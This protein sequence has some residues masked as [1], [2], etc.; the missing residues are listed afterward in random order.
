M[1]TIIAAAAMSVLG[2]AQVSAESIEIRR[3]GQT[4]SVIGK[5]D[6][7]S[8]HAVVNP[9]LP[10]NE[11]TRANLGRVDFA[12]GARTA[13]HTH[14]AGQLLIVTAGKGWVQEEGK[15]RQDITSGDVVWIPATVRHWHG[16]TTTSPMSHLAMTYMV[17]G[18]NVD[19]QEPVS[20][21]Q[22]Q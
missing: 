2:A 16:A 22:Y 12:P 11:S 8:G 6:N 14:P 20:D 19:W 3:N 1:K 21:E 10:P 4:P 7:F 5:A 15:V 9:L 13:W 18:K 17:D